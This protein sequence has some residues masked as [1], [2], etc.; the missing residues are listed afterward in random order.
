MIVLRAADTTKKRFLFVGLIIPIHIG[1]HL[2][3][4]QRTDDDTRVFP[5]RGTQNTN[6]MR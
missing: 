6:S 2:Y 1:K 4:V 3:L 5:I